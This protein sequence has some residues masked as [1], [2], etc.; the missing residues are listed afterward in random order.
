MITF[1]NLKNGDKLY[2]IRKDTF[3]IIETYID[4]DDLNRYKITLDSLYI[5]AYRGPNTVFKCKHGNVSCGFHLN[6]IYFNKEDAIKNRIIY[7]KEAIQKKEYW[8][9]SE[10][11]W[12]TKEIEK[13]NEYL[14]KTL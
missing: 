12:R 10:V 9:N 8:L 13:L 3:D 11:K 4:E 6:T 7:L 1:E 5:I 2:Y 14:N